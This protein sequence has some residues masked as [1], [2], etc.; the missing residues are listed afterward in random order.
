MPSR[1]RV[2]AL[3]PQVSCAPRVGADVRAAVL[4]PGPV[5]GPHTWWIRDR[6]DRAQGNHDNE[7][8]WFGPAPLIGDPSWP[9][10][11]LVAMDRWL[12]SVELDHS[13]ASRAKK[14]AAD[15]PADLQDRCTADICKQEAATRYGTPRSVAGGSEFN[16]V[17][18]CRLR[19]LD[20]ND[21]AG[22]TFTDAAWATLEKTFPTGVCDWSKPGVGQ[23]PNIAWLTYQDAAGNVIY[24][25]RPMGPAPRSAPLG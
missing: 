6:L 21:Y 5:R 4:A 22:V 7:V 9:T 17:V 8:L 15:K 25:G 18:K 13:G 12:R 1:R 23:Q 24:G 20:R 11:A 14:I 16:D 2:G 3:P 19:P 10:E